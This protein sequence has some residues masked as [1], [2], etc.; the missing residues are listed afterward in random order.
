MCLRRIGDSDLLPGGSWWC[1]A[2]R[3]ALCRGDSSIGCVLSRPVSVNFVGRARELALW[4]AVL[5]RLAAGRAAVVVVLGG[6]AGVGK[7]RL[8]AQFAV[9]AQRIDARALSGCCVELG[10]AGLPFA[11]FAG[12]LRSLVRDIGVPRLID[13]VDGATE[14]FSRLLPELGRQPAGADGGQARLFALTLRLIERLSAERPLVLLIEDLHWAD[15]STLDLIGF[16]VRNLHDVPVALVLTARND[17]V[18]TRAGPQSFLA[19]LDRLEQ[20]TRIDVPRLARR[21]VIE[22]LRG[23]VGAPPPRSWAQRIFTRSGGNPFFVEVLAA[24]GPADADD[25]ESGTR[26]PTSLSELLLA[27]VRRLPEA[28]A[29]LLRLAAVAGQ[30]VSHRLLVHMTGL[31]DEPLTDTVRAAI[32][33][34][35]LV[36]DS[37][38]E[39]YAFRHAL[40]REALYAD[41]LP[42]ERVRLHTR[43]AEALQRNPQLSPDD[44]VPADLAHHW[45]A[46]GRPAQAL[47]AVLRAAERAAGQYA[48]AER[49]HLLERAIQLWHQLDAPGAVADLTLVQLLD[50]ASA[51]AYEAGA[52][53]RALELLDAALEAADWQAEAERVAMLHIRR[54][55]LLRVSGRDGWVEAARLAETLVPEQSPTR[56]KVLASVAFSLQL[57]FVL[58][59]EPRLDE[60][61]RLC[62]EA[63]ALAQRDPDQANRIW[64]RIVLGAILVNLHD[65]A[66]AIEHFQVGLRTA[67]AIDD[68]KLFAQA[69]VALSDALE[70]AGRYAEAVDVG[71]QAIDHFERVGLSPTWAAPVASNLGDALLRLGRWQE[72]DSVTA[73]AFSSDPPAFHT[74]RFYQLQGD[75][76]AARGDLSAARANRDAFRDGLAGNHPVVH[77]HL[78]LARLEMEIALWDGR[79]ADACQVL[80]AALDGVLRPG[81]ALRGWPVLSLGARAVADAAE[82]R[83]STHKRRGAGDLTAIAE[84]IRTVADR[85]PTNT[86]PAR[87]HA[88][89]VVAELTRFAG[90]R[91]AVAW[92]TASTEADRLDDPYLR[93]YVYLRTAEAIAVAGDRAG[94]DDLLARGAER[95]DD[96]GAAPLRRAITR[97]TRQLARLP[98]T[99][100]RNPVDIYELTER[101]R[102]IVALVVSGMTNAEVAGRLFV[103]SKTVEFH[104]GNIYAKLGL[105]GRRELR[106]YVQ[107]SRSTVRAWRG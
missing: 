73:K 10:A 17:E 102:E 41:L 25:R 15:R 49:H 83:R 43:L 46:A 9:Q 52:V 48:F 70:L 75:L 20:V 1:D 95:A 76:A 62:E 91:C 14:E 86:Q 77:E 56:A 54:G 106:E 61:R 30:A 81:A 6:E 33:G 13:L 101:E 67:R 100:R 36:V 16:L 19:E 23:I 64:A 45:F 57:A 28:T 34:H 68:D 55:R 29:R 27:R 63:L 105:T 103:S 80:T 40:I 44:R 87:V 22:Q 53:D 84:R 3:T 92:R 66:P 12:A 2:V 35:V 97:A 5:D 74:T 47:P 38:E 65:I 58:Q 90:R 94:A 50:T 7:S 79:P 51:A 69:A 11:P 26:L 24:A 96:L 99:R 42:A 21:D 89:L 98:A 85:L 78:P 107:S 32:D 60:A 8:A 104:L 31:D 39:G 93:A 82:H 4:S 88:A 18:D 71:N 37:A 72:V 59:L